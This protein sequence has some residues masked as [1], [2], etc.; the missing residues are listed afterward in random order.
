MMPADLFHRCPV[1][2]LMLPAVENQRDDRCPSCL[3]SEGRGVQMDLITLTATSEP[4]HVAP[5]TPH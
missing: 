2:E 4:R 1:C 5:K 3:M